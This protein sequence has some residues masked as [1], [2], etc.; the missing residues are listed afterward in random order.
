MII[1]IYFMT[2]QDYEWVWKWEESTSMFPGQNV[3]D[4]ISTD[5][6][7]PAFKDITW[8]EG[9]EDLEGYEALFS[10]E[11]STFKGCKVDDGKGYQDV[12]SWEYL[13]KYN[14]QMRDSKKMMRCQEIEAVGPIKQTKIN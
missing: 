3:I 10:T 8:E 13:L 7:T 6:S 11:W 14:G 12:W 4:Q 1:V 2:G 5:W 9:C